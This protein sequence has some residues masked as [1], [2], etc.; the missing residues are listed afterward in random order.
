MSPKRGP[1]HEARLI[2]RIEGLLTN[3]EACHSARLPLPAEDVRLA[4][5][6]IRLYATQ[7]S[8]YE[9]WIDREHARHIAK[10]FKNNRL[11]GSAF[12][13]SQGTPDP[14]GRGRNMSSRLSQRVAESQTPTANPPPTLNR[15]IRTRDNSASFPRKI[16]LP[17]RATEL[18]EYSVERRQ[19]GQL[20]WRDAQTTEPS[21][22]ALFSRWNSP[23]PS[24]V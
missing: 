24:R 16:G 7:E 8:E 12:P 23:P 10:L 2:A 13:A 9:A 19:F 3:L 6:L 18:S 11:L 20:A 21:G 5:T 4:A 22:A 17:E 15:A 14:R 1:V